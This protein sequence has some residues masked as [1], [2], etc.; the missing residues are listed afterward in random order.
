MVYTTQ[1]SPVVN[2]DFAFGKIMYLFLHLCYKLQIDQ[3]LISEL[4]QK[5]HSFC[6]LIIGIS[7]QLP[8]V[9][10]L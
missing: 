10:R 6:Y 2:I 7:R 5:I 9:N 1:G 3:C 4:S 8:R